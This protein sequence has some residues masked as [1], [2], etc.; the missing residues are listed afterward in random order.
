MRKAIRVCA[1]VFAITL[2]ALPASAAQLSDVALYKLNN[3]ADA[4]A[5]CDIT[6]FLLTNPENKAAVIS[7]N[8][9]DAPASPKSPVPPPSFSSDV[10]RE[11]YERL[12]QD[13]LVTPDSYRRARRHYASVMLNA[14]Q[15]SSAAER[16]TLSD[17]MA[18][19]YHLAAREGVKPRIQRT[20]TKH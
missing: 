5:V 4:I 13:S 14:Y 20:E 17:Q 7:M 1:S 18:L 6:R 10:M 16:R 11:T 19:C 9:K 12:H 15:D 3:W 8:Q 2:L